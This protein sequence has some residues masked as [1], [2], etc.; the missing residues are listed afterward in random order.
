MGGAAFEHITAM[1]ICR[2]S[3][4]FLSAKDMCKLNAAGI[5]FQ[6]SLLALIEIIELFS[7]S[8]SMKCTIVWCVCCVSVVFEWGLCVCGVNDSVNGEAKKD[9]VCCTITTLKDEEKDTLY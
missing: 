7:S 1:P 8:V 2:V 3:L 9:W 5:L 6:P 4:A